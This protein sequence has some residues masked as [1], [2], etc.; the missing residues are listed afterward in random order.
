MSSS[1]NYRNIQKWTYKIHFPRL[2]KNVEAMS[3][4]GHSIESYQKMRQ[5]LRLHVSVANIPDRG[6]LLEIDE[7]K[8]PDMFLPNDLEPTNPDKR[9][10]ADADYTANDATLLGILGLVPPKYSDHDLVAYKVRAP[11]SLTSAGAIKCPNPM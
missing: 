3:A 10:Q 1:K 2:S 8:F 4:S 6:K 11:N 5:S 7:G 9:V